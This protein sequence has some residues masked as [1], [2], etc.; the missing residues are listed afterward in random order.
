MIK[1]QQK[2]PLD[3]WCIAGDVLE[4]KGY[5]I[6]YLVREDALRGP[7]SAFKRVMGF[8][9]KSWCLG[10]TGLADI[11]W[12]MCWDQKVRNKVQLWPPDVSAFGF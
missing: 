5:H 4:S 11:L 7:N 10:D 12:F 8:I 3:F 9:N 1:I 6:I 2:P